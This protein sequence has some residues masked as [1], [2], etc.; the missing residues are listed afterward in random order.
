MYSGGTEKMK[1]YVSVFFISVF[2]VFLLCS[3]RMYGFIPASER[4]ALIAL[5]HSTNGDNWT[6]HSGWKDGTLESDGFAAIGSEGNWYGITVPGDHVTKIHLSGNNLKGNIPPE[7][8]NLPYLE[9]LYLG[10]DSPD[11]QNRLTGTIPAALGDLTR[12]KEL[13]LSYNYWMEFSLEPIIQ[14]TEL[15]YL[16]LSYLD[17]R[18]PMPSRIGELVKLR[19][20][21]WFFAYITDIPPELSRLTW[22]EEL[23]LGYNDIPSLPPQI[24][25]LVNLINL[26]LGDNLISQLPPEIGNLRNL[27]R[28]NVSLNYLTTLPP[29]IGNLTNLKYLEAAA[30]FNLNTLPETIGGLANLE[31]LDLLNCDLNFLPASFGNLGKLKYLDINFNNISAWEAPILARL[32]N[33]EYLDLTNNKFEWLPRELGS[34]VNLKTLHVTLIEEMTGPIPP[35]LGNLARLEQLELHNNNLT[36]TIPPQLGNLANL[37]RIDLSYN[38][39]S[40]NLP[41][42]LGNLQN[43]EYLELSNNQL[44]GA[45]PGELGNMAILKEL[46]LNNN[47]FSGMV[48]REI[49]NLVNLEKIWLYNNRFSGLPAEIGKLIKIE[50]LCLDDNEITALPSEIEDMPLLEGIWCQRNQ[51]SDLPS[52]I[53]QVPNLKTLILSDNRLTHIPPQLVQCPKLKSLSLSGNLIRS[54]SPLIGDLVTLTGLNLSG[55]QLTDLPSSMS[56]LSLGSLSLGRNRFTQF[57]AVVLQM[58]SLEFLD[59]SKNSI[60]GSIPHKLGDLVHLNTLDISGNKITGPVPSSI[61]NLTELGVSYSSWDDPYVNFGYNML[62]SDDEA[63]REYLDTRDHG[64]QDSQTVPPTDLYAVPY[65]NNSVKVTW[66]PI[67]YKIGTGKY[68]VYYSTSAVGPWIPAGSTDSNYAEYFQVTGLEKGITYYFTVRTFTDAHDNNPNPLTSPSSAIVSG[69]ITSPVPGDQPPFGCIDLPL[70]GS[71]GLSGSIPVCGWA[72]DDN[73]ITGVKIYRLSGGM[74]IY[75]GDAVFIEGARPDVAAAYPGYPG[76]TRA[77]WGY[78]LLTNTLPEGGNGLYILLAAAYDSANQETILGTRKIVCDNENAVKPFGTIDTPAQGGIA[79]G[80]VYRN[81]GWVLTPLPNKIPEDGSTINVYLDGVFLGHPAYNIFSQ[82]IAGIFP[83]YANSLGAVA[84]FDFD[85]TVYPDGIHTI[86]W[87]AADDAGN[88]DGIGSRYFVIQNQNMSVYASGR[89]QNFMIPGDY[90]EPVWAKKGWESDSM[91]Q[92]VIP[93]EKGFRTIKTHGLERL[94]IDLFP[95]D[96]RRAVFSGYLSAGDKLYPLPIGSTLDRESGIFYWC[97]GPGFIGEYRLVFIKTVDNEP[98]SSKMVSIKIE[99]R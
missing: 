10:G 30:N 39:L 78:M 88:I 11:V 87:T 50:F 89:I 27:E 26:D 52:T 62:Y 54:L 4:T 2:M 84:Y 86:Y 90:L 67:R 13:D 29:E 95:G 1:K 73:A 18:G 31:Y 43:L 23:D 25:D 93:D 68:L 85:T 46:H 82:H 71:V 91:P 45:L 3:A 6:D 16:N 12:L 94:V 60:A 28:L 24:G 77:G 35:E 15:E 7:I 51:L 48:P 47:Q 92:E 40:G 83:Q 38:Q 20:L 80:H 75:I 69:S 14:L 5:Y 61:L 21:N 36:G 79:A 57:P 53:G 22:L 64:W 32:T 33:L 56:N 72:L 8:G 9:E 70:P 99:M 58:T 42:E 81:Q 37:K 66:T 19:H 98:G 55:N 65:Y 44:A 59:L 17:I 96:T 49:G 74:R 41:R 97:P 76:N 34:L 63:V